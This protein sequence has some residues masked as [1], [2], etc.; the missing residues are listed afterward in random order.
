MLIP[1]VKSARK[2]CLTVIGLIA[3]CGVITIVAA[4]N[5]GGI[6]I[7]AGPVLI[8]AGGE[9]GGLKAGLRDSYDFHLIVNLSETRRIRIK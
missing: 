1:Q 4:Q 2:A 7:A 6:E 3:I 9:T 8:T 5:D